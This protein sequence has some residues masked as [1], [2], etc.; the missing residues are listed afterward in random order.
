MSKFKL[1]RLII[2]FF[3][4]LILFAYAYVSLVLNLNPY[5]V[6]P[7]PR[8]SGLC[9]TLASRQDYS[10]Y[11]HKIITLLPML[12]ITIS[13]GLVLFVRNFDRKSIK[14][15]SLAIAIVFILSF[16][17]FFILR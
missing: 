8:F 2:L 11:L 12:A 17:L 16:V 1:L 3:F 13:V 14:A 15:L 4:F 5:C 6:V 10:S 9:T 7:F